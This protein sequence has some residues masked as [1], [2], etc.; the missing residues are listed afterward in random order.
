MDEK[1]KRL[2]EL[3]KERAIAFGKFTL[4][5]GKESNYYIN[6]KKAIFHSEAISL[7]ADLF[8][9]M[10]KDQDIQAVGGLE[11]GAIPLT[12]ALVQRYHQAG[13]EMEG[14]FV[15]KQEKSHGSRGRVEGVVKPGGNIA[16]LEDVIN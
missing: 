3:F 9:E 8:F 5:S 7:V 12:A 6:S 10:T 15:R 16:L 11:I 14:F 13:R 2:L 1:R 4:A